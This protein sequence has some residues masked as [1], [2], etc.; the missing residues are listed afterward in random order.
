[1]FT[2][3]ANFN[4]MNCERQLDK[5]LYMYVYDIFECKLKNQSLSPEN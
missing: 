2:Y 4:V 1:M 3:I 5:T